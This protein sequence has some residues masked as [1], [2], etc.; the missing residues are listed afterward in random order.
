M[1]TKKKTYIDQILSDVA[2]SNICYS[3]FSSQFIYTNVISNTSQIFEAEHIDYFVSYIYRYLFCTHWIQS[4]LYWLIA[5]TKWDSWYACATASSSLSLFSVKKLKLD[6][7]LLI[8][9]NFNRITKRNVFYFLWYFKIRLIQI[10]IQ[11]EM[12]GLGS[13]LP[14]PLLF[15]V[16]QELL[17]AT[18]FFWLLVLQ[19]FGFENYSFWNVALKHEKLPLRFSFKYKFDI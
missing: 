8:W 15:G 10:L 19:Y 5:L 2:W 1:Q 3:S 11:W 12:V 9:E 16:Q 18:N 6:I 17:F 4:G 7:E 14:K 13:G